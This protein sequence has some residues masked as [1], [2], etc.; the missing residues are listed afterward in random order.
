M[1][2]EDGQIE[3]VGQARGIKQAL[4]KMVEYIGEVGENIEQK[5]LIIANCNCHERAKSVE[6]KIKER[7]AFKSVKIIDTKGISSL[8]AAD[9]GIIVAF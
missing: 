9:G 5:D 2:A 7:Y 3:Q 8:Y 6:E 4:T 1:K